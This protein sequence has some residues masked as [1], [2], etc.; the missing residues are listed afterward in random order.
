MA[1]DAWS[2]DGRVLR[3][4]S[5]TAARVEACDVVIPRL[6]NNVGF[7]LT[8]GLEL[9]RLHHV[10]L[11]LGV[12]VHF[13]SSDNGSRTSWDTGTRST[14]PV[15]HVKLAFPF[16]P[17]MPLQDCQPRPPWRTLRGPPAWRLG[18]RGL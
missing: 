1:L 6:V 13:S 14:F 12:D 11:Q 5:M 17:R 7:K 2:T 16:F 9:F 8:A 10:R 15:A 18:F 4:V 3:S